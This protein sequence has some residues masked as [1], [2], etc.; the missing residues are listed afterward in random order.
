V[1]VVFLERIDV[2]VL[3]DLVG[4]EIVNARTLLSHQLVDR[5]AQDGLGRRVRGNAAY[6]SNVAIS[7]SVTA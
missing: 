4:W 1:P 5:Y 2:D 7:G 6:R 3:D